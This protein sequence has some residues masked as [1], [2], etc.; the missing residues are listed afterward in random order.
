[1]QTPD[2]RKNDERRNNPA[3]ASVL[4]GFLR[5]ERRTGA[6]RRSRKGKFKGPSKSR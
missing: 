2:S 1:M 3:A 6:D 5:K 4:G